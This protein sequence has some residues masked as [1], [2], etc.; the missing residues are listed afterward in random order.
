MNPILD[1]EKV[2]L[3][4]LEFVV[5]H[6]MLHAVCEPLIDSRG[7]TWVHTREFR[8]REKLHPFFASAKAWEKQ[9]LTVLKRITYGRA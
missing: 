2:P 4:F 6:E 1:H 3:F 8:A 7:R 5:Y 9:S